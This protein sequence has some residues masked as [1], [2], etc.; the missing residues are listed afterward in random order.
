MPRISRTR[1]V[2]FVAT[3]LILFVIRFDILFATSLSQF[4]GNSIFLVT[5]SF[6]KNQGPALDADR[7]PGTCLFILT[8]YEAVLARVADDSH[9]LDSLSCSAGVLDNQPDRIK[10]V[11]I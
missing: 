2:K 10:L 8:D 5:S 11:R 6:S 4:F 1:F 3:V 7:F 9:V